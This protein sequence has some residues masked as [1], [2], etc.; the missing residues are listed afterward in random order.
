MKWKFVICWLFSFPIKIDSIKSLFTAKK[1]ILWKVSKCKME[2][3]LRDR[4]TWK[5]YKKKRE[6]I[7]RWRG[8]T[9]VEKNRKKIDI[10]GA[11]IKVALELRFEVNTWQ[12]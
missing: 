11:L 9:S 4:M 7:E 1:I 8:A 10:R 2:I 3:D 6:N 5:K 12:R